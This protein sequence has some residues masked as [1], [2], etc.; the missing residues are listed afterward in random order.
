MQALTHVRDGRAADMGLISLRP[1]A[2]ENRGRALG[3]VT[4]GHAT[5][6]RPRM[7]LISTMRINQSTLTHT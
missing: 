1:T 7:A 2:I 5:C 3:D 4:R 6:T